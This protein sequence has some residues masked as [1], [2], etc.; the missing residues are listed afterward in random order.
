VSINYNSLYGI[1]RT[2]ASK[3]NPA[4]VALGRLGGKK[5]GKARVPKGISTLSAEERTA[6]S[7]KG[8]AARRKNAK[9]KAK[10]KKVADKK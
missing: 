4:A 3:K 7:M 2:M 1:I 6:M 5:G 8:V 10:D 9:K